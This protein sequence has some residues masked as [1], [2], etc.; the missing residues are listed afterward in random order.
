MPVSV[1]ICNGDINTDVVVHTDAIA[2]SVGVAFT[3]RLVNLHA[4]SIHHGNTHADTIHHGNLYAILIWDSHLD[5]IIDTFCNKD[6]VYHHISHC[7]W[8]RYTNPN[9]LKQRD[10]YCY[11]HNG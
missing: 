5:S 1:T 4:G 2:H 9:P 3:S 6:H 7:N 8:N 10:Y 11:T